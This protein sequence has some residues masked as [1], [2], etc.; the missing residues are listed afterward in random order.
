MV[1]SPESS[2]WTLRIHKVGKAPSLEGNFCILLLLGKKLW[3]RLVALYK[4]YLRQ[5]KALFMH[6]RLRRRTR[7]DIN[8]RLPPAQVGGGNCKDIDEVE[9]NFN[10]NWNDDNLAWCTWCVGSNH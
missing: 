5:K 2:E 1:H 6:I 8:A 7:E 9:S 3:S 10:K 4:L